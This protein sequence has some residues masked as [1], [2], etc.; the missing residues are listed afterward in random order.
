MPSPGDKTVWDP[1]KTETSK[2]VQASV[3][4]SW[5]PGSN[6]QAWLGRS[7]PSAP[8]TD[9]VK[10]EIVNSQFYVRMKAYIEYWTAKNPGDHK[11]PLSIHLYNSPAL[12]AA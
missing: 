9:A 11:M 12:D 4:K 10:T 3:K 1:A 7:T 2:P 5:R 8:K 6:I